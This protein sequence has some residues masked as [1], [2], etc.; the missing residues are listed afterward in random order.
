MAALNGKE[1]ENVALDCFVRYLEAS[2]SVVE[3]MKSA[4]VVKNHA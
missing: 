3:V 2:S 4:L 1:F